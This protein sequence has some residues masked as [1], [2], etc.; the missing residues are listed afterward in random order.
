MCRESG[1]KLAG[2]KFELAVRV[3][4]HKSGVS[5][6]A[7][8]PAAAAPAPVA[9]KK[10]AAEDPAPTPTHQP[11]MRHTDLKKPRVSSASVLSPL[12]AN[13][14]SPKASLPPPPPPPP[15]EA[16]SWQAIL[17][18][19]SGAYGGMGGM[20]GTCTNGWGGMG[21]LARSGYRPVRL[22]PDATPETPPFTP[23]GKTYYYNAGTG[24]TT[25]TSECMHV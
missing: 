2:T 7:A 5:P 13:T 22:E 21:G 25:W 20:G 17:D 12:D 1:L 18:K 4:R 10:R 11:W 16:S 8:P 15:S 24:V 3:I 23:S 6:A 19:T 14:L 9:S